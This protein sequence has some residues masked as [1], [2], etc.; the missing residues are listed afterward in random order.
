MN[1]KI[2]EFDAE[3]KKAPDMDAAYIEFPYDLKKEFGKRRIKVH[4]EFDGEHYDG[5]IVNM[6]VKHA[7]GSVC[8][9]IGIR[10]EIRQKIGKQAGNMLHVTVEERK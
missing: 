1:N 6:G 3:I 5:S 8:Y 7:D 10:K 2:Y 9:V 4:A